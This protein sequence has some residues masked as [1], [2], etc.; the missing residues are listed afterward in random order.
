MLRER[1]TM[2]ENFFQKKRK[3]K[4]GLRRKIKGTHAEE[5]NNRSKRGK[6]KMQIVLRG[7]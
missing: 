2:R 6:S 1:K 3:R 4:K 7:K 5:E